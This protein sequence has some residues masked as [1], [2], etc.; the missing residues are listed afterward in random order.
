MPARGETGDKRLSINS[1]GNDLQHMGHLVIIQS[2]LCKT[3]NNAAL[4]K[5]VLREKENYGK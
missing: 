1:R 3:Q 5:H 2:I 4:P